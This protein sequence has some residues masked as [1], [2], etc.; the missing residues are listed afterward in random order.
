[1][2]NNYSHINY[3]LLLCFHGKIETGDHGI[4]TMKIMGRIPVSMLK[5]I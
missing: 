5:P 2:E 1:M 4:F 3:I